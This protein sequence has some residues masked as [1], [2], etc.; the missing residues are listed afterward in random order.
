MEDITF[1]DY[2]EPIVGLQYK[3]AWYPIADIYEPVGDFPDIESKKVVVFGVGE[4]RAEEGGKSCVGADAVRKQFYNF[5][6][7]EFHC[8]IADLGNLIRGFELKDTYRA[9]EDICYSLL[10]QD[11]KSVV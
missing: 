2:F 8:G 9:V 6:P 10:L 5:Y 4:D 1:Q 3:K 7:K 11:R